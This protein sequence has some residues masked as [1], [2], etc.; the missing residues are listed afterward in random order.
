M[1]PNQ[2]SN[3]LLTEWLNNRFTKDVYT[4]CETLL[5]DIEEQLIK[6][7]G[8]NRTPEQDGIFSKELRAKREGLL[9]FLGNEWV[10]HL[11]N[12]ETPI[13]IEINE[14]IDPYE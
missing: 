2:S 14:E 8:A 7:D 9:A 11:P 1:K 10:R 3:L 6:G 5:D 4:A 13:E 12:Q